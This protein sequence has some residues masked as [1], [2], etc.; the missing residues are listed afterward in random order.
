MKRITVVATVLTLTALTG[1]A[2]AFPPPRQPQRPG[3]HKRVHGHSFLHPKRMKQLD[4]GKHHV[5]TTGSKHKIHASLRGGKVS[6][7]HVTDN[8]GRNVKVHKKL[9]RGRTRARAALETD[10]V[11]LALAGTDLEGEELTPVSQLGLQ[12]F[13]V[14]SFTDPAT[15]Q[16]I[17]I[18]FPAS[19]IFGGNQLGNGGNLPIDLNVPTDPAG[20]GVDGV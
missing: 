3:A 8:R 20:G 16:T 2:A 13:V 6:G 7:L 10:P 11:A 18:F 17:L 12:V 5:H 4:A 15:G 9:V 14:F 19:S 1:L